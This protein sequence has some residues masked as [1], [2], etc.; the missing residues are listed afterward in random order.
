MPAV[1]SAIGSEEFCRD[2]R[3]NL[4]NRLGPTNDATV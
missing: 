3:F 2:Y 1:C 4:A